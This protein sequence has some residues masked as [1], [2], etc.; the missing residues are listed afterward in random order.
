MQRARRV[1]RIDD[2]ERLVHAHQD[3]LARRHLAPDQRQVH[4]VGRHVP[5][6]HQP[7]APVGGLDLALGDPLHQRLGAAAIVDQIGDGA[8]LQPVL[9][10]EREQV[11]QTRHLAVVAQDFADHG[12][13]HE[14]GQLG[15]VAPGLGVPG[16]HQH[17]AGLRHER[18]DVAGLHQVLRP[19]F[20]A[21]RRLHRARAVRR[22][23]AGRHTAGGFDG[24]G[25][26]GAQLRLVVVDHQR[27]VELAA[28]RLRQREADQP[29]AVL[30]HEVDG[31][32]GDELG[33]HDQVAFV[34]AI[35][36]VDQDHHAAGLDLGDDPRCAG[37]A[38]LCC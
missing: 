23:D 11:R 37:D 22:R 2:R 17:A 24:H 29:A 35:L 15:Q 14:P 9:V 36:F 32:S 5:K 30:G 10:G 19:R 3:F 18:E 27:Q 34:L 28:A 12:R 38:R 25:E 6:R 16:T 8:D 31:S 1:Q 13:G 21:H 26:V 7:E 4:L 33:G 20:P